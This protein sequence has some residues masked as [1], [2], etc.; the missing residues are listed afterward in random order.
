MSAMV[1][2]ESPVL[3]TGGTGTLGRPLVEGLLAADVP[4]RVMSRRP[5]PAGDER[6]LEWAVG[7]LGKGEGIEP[8]VAGAGTIVHCATT[9]RHDVAMTRRLVEAARRAGSPQSPDTPHLV[10]V[11][12][13]GVDR[14]PFFYY[15]AKLETE[16]I[17]E[18]SGLPWTILRATQFHDLVAGVVLAQRR[19]PVVLVPRGFRFQPVEAAEVAGRL[20]ELVQGAPAGRVDD[21]GGPQVRDVADLAAAT[22]EAAGLRRRLVRAPLPGGTARAF[23]EGGH[24][25]PDHAVGEVTFEQYLAAR[26]KAGRL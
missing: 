22:L 15:R 10:H 1:G 14:V 25:T 26:A 13:V 9:G 8:A 7:D 16:R 3:V 20:V 19:S 24:L 21:M 2:P 12:I 17:I 6:R 23:R 4:V 5:R 18:G 11:S